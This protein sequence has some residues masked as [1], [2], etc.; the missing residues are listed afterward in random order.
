MS[1]SVLLEPNMELIIS[2]RNPTTAEFKELRQLAGWPLPDDNRIETGLRNTI[3]A[4]VIHDSAQRIMGMGRILGDNAIY[5][6]IQDV[7]VRPT[8]QRHGIGRLIMNELMKY[9]ETTAGNHSNIGLMCS[10]GREGFYRKYGFIDRPNE[11][12]GA[13]MI[14]VKGNILNEK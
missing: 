7:I 11:K 12:F 14:I 4:V 13:G 9:L 6:H 3:H 2:I 8:A 5:F 1:E 10:V